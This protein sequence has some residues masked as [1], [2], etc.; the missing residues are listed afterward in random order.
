[1]KFLNVFAA[2]SG[3][4]ILIAGSNGKTEILMTSFSLETEEFSK[5]VKLEGVGQQLSQIEFLEGNSIVSGD[6]RGTI[7]LYSQNQLTKSVKAH[8]PDC[9]N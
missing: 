3:E 8:Y 6:V 9:I 5:I 2:E 1:M 4:N 7:N